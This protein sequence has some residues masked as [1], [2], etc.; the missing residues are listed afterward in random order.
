MAVTGMRRH[1][2]RSLL[3]VT[4]ALFALA[5]IGVASAQVGTPKPITDEARKIEDLWIFTLALAAVV[6]VVVEG[7]RKSVV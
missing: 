6:F 3:L 4:V 2:R 1:V 7:D 5:S